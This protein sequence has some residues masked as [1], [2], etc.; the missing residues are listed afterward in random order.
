MAF[1]VSKG[2]AIAFRLG[3]HHL[4][5]RLSENGLLDAAGRC[6][7]QNSPP[8][9]AQLALHARVRNL[10]PERVADAVAEERSLL[11]SWCMRGSPF[12]FPTADA[13]VFTTGVL[14]P[15]EEA[16]RHFVLGAEQSLVRLNMSLTETVELTG[17]EIGGVLSGRQ[18]AI[19]EL[20]AELATRISQRLPKKQRDVWEEEGPHAAGQP[21]G[22]AVVHFC[23]RVLTLQ[24]VIC[25]APR[26]GN[27]APF[28][29]VE[30]WLGDP[31]P[32]IDPEVARAELLR[33]YLHCYGPSTRRDFA[34]WLGIRAGD[35]APWW[36]PVADELTR[37][38]FGGTS[39][40]LTEDLDALRSAP[41]PEGV[42]LLPPRDPY[43]Q[44]RDR[45]TIVDKPCHQEVWKTVG[46]PGTVLAGGRITGIWRPRKRG[47]K[48]T[49]AITTF[50][51]L[52][53]RD[54]KALRNE[55][56][57]IAPL[58]GASSVDVEF[59]T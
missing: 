47:R 28:I 23:I 34:A 43:T 57:Q 18:L 21:L 13:P 46:E 29:L 25:F 20:G 1:K 14:P 53:V 44:L 15:T 55:A 38:E 9:S 2:D 54:K 10:T 30:E 5:E 52:P 37:V 26:A 45:D 50:G 51:S 58:R 24:R 35:T 3:A 17:A 32:D 36:N 27:K 41:K 6:G 31:I 4:T 7:I 19:N 40:V 49:I 8:G 42:R 16:M 33:R 11:Q 59:G 48:L 56:E 22:E 12:F 39:W